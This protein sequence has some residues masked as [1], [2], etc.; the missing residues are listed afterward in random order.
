MYLYVWAFDVPDEH[1][2]AFER[3]YGPEGEW[4]AL[5]RRAA[6]YRS[7]R[8]LRLRDG[9]YLTIDEWES[10]SCYEDFRSTFAGEYEALDARSAH[11]TL[12]EERLLAL[13]GEEVGGGSGPR[14]GGRDDEARR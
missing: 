7:T 14:S 11:M 8:L 6:G 1:R 4:V 3:A 9:R 12:A 5:F 10:L 13:D 2:S